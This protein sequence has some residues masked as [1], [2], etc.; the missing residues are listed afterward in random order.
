MKQRFAFLAVL[1]AFFTLNFLN[2]QSELVKNF[3][4][5]QDQCPCSGAFTQIQLYYF[6]DNNVK[7]EVFANSDLSALVALFNGVNNGQPLTL[8]ASGLPGGAFTQHVFLRVTKADGSSCVT[9]IYARCPTNAWPGATDDLRILGK[10]YGNFTVFSHT[11]QGGATLCDLSSVEQD[12]HV[13]GNVVAGGANTLGTKNNENMVI[14][15]NNTPRGVVTNSGNFGIGTTAPASRLDVSGNARISEELR[16]AGQIF[17]QNNTESLHSG[18]GAVIVAGGVGIGRQLNV[19]T[20]LQVN[21]T[22]QV[23]SNLGVGANLSVTGMATIGS[24]L[25]V[26][27]A[28]TVMIQNNTDA[29]S[30][31]SGALMVAGGA[32]IGARLYVGSDLNVG[33][34]GSVARDLGVGMDLNVG[35]DIAAARNVAAGQ[36]LSAGRNLSVTRNATVGQ[37]LYVSRDATIN[38]HLNIL[39]NAHISG[40]LQV[41]AAAT[42]TGYLASFD[43]RVMCEEIRVRNSTNWPDY[44]FADAYPLLS[45][46]ALEAYIKTHKHLPGLPSAAAVEAEAGFDLGEIQRLQMEKIEELTLYAI[47][48]N[49]ENA[50][51][52]RQLEQTNGALELILT[53]LAALETKK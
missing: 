7:V 15:T 5:C 14:I 8:N 36:D 52:K 3:D 27:P 47:A 28:G 50:Q 34:D 25:I 30:P 9:R 32:G 17:A 13:G 11:D 20:N 6:G 1:A 42:P 12:W 29:A 2:A 53:R 37:D 16:V 46:D 4:F 26:Q 43:G 39:Q 10:T 40:R 22:G 38:R 19:G 24:D 23:D 41:G 49:K 18:S 21:G 44:V 35:Q 48:L 33:N 45:L 31:N 51:L